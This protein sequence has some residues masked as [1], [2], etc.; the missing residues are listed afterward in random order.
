[1]DRETGEVLPEAYGRCDRE[2]NCGYFCSPYA[3]A[4]S[5]MSFADE[6][7]GPP[8]PKEWF[9]MA[10]AWKRQHI[11]RQGVVLAL[12]QQGATPDQSERVAAYVFDRSEP[13]PMPPP[14]YCLP[15]E[16]MQKSLGHYERNQF[17]RFLTARFGDEVARDLLNRFQVG[18]SSRWDGAN[19]FWLIDEESRVRGGQICLY[20]GTGHKVKHTYRDEEGNPKTRVC[21]TSVRAALKWKYRD[22]SPPDWL[23]AYPDDAETW[24]VLFGL[25][26]LQHTPTNTPV[27]L[28]EG[29]KTALVCSH[30]LR[31]SGFIWLAVGGKSYLKAERLA[32]LRGRKL[33]LYPDLGAY[34]DTTNARG[35]TIR[36]WL[37][38]ATQLRAEG[39]DVT[40]SDVL[41]QLATDEDRGAG[42]LD[43]AD[44]LLRE[45]NRIKSFADW[46]PGQVVTLDE[47]HVERLD[48][49]TTT[50]GCPGEWDEPAPP[51]AMPTI[52]AQTVEEYFVMVCGRQHSRR[53][54]M[55]EVERLYWLYWQRYARPPL[56]WNR[57]GTHRQ[58]LALLGLPIPNL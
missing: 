9:Q 34:H 45:P 55:A 37:T 8:I 19:I 51:G 39:F 41:E 15:T 10:G 7:K 38:L 4:A 36:G 6:Q 58:V 11:T 3:K 13:T 46:L 40:V 47:A 49:P 31:D 33:M 22:M 2:S 35:Q 18:T 1:M 29:P 14:I 50:E 16:V 57:I 26:Q 48:V 56:V 5:G 21:I 20:D 25:P 53:G 17:A 42:G 32:A 43:L 54:L 52:Q 30:L 27:A 23:V 12:V 44:F 28:V 24:P